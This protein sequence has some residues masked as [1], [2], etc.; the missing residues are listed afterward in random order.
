MANTFDPDLIATVDEF[1]AT[2]GEAG[3]Y[4]PLVGASRAI[5]CIV[6][7]GQVGD[8]EGVPRGLQGFNMTIEV[9]NDVTKGILVTEIDTGGDKF[10]IP[11]NI[12]EAVKQKRITKIISQDAGMIT[13]ALI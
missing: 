8:I 7:R 12:G 2:F 3:T 11:E 1:L 9:A 5:T 6:N 4:Y 10:S 13:L